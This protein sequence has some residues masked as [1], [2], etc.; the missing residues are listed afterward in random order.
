LK[1][2]E[3]SVTPVEGEKYLLLFKN[4]S[5]YG[6]VINKKK[7]IVVKENRIIL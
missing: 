2:S 4:V 5:F 1:K 3:V 7:Y 6:K